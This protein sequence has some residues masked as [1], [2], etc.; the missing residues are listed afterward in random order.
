M[1][2]EFRSCLFNSSKLQGNADA[3][4]YVNS[5]SQAQTQANMGAA[6]LATLAKV[7]DC[8]FASRTFQTTTYTSHYDQ[9]EDTSR[10]F[11]ISTA[12]IC[13]HPSWYKCL[14]L[15]E[16][17]GSASY[18]AGSQDMKYIHIFG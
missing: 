7:L 16:P 18:D 15:E 5:S 17:H 3:N 9:L 6:V 14:L 1:V 11:A 12:E 13:R 4:G 2:V 10:L 8:G